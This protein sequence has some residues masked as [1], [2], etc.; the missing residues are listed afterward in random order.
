MV[1]T[2]IEKKYQPYQQDL[3]EVE[4]MIINSC[5]KHYSFYQELVEPLLKSGG[6]RLRPLLTLISFKLNS[7]ICKKAYPVAAAVEL[8]HTASL[9]H[10]DVID[11]AELRRGEAS[12][13]QVWGNE[14]SVLIGDFLFTRAFNLLNK[15]GNREV[16]NIITE[17][18]TCMCQGQIMEVRG[19]SNIFLTQGEYLKII[20]LK[21]CSLLQA[22]CLAG[23]ATGK[24]HS[25]YAKIMADYALNLGRIF[26]IKDDLLDLS[27][28]SQKTG[29]THFKD[30]QEK[31]VTLPLIL[32]FADPCY[33]HLAR[34]LFLKAEHNPEAVTEIKNIFQASKAARE[35]DEVI[36]YFYCQAR[37]ELEQLPC[38]ESREALENILDKIKN[39]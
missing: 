26:Q 14:I 21:T 39:Y 29:K 35:L 22:S 27:L 18:V 17:A 16:I 15:T 6:K 5:T 37:R 7:S 31:V 20:D 25:P 4:N 12:L 19:K 28:S 8:I 30:I 9:V 11:R 24:L 2:Q 13:N 23:A 36:G 34:E 32:L 1:K 38:S 33:G 3:E 10:D